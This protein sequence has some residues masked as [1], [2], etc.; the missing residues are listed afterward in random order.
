MVGT[1]LSGQ[2][3]KSTKQKQENLVEHMKHLGAAG[4]I[5]AP[6]PQMQ[7]GFTRRQI[8][9]PPS[10]IRKGSGKSRIKTCATSKIAAVLMR[11]RH[12]IPVVE[13]FTVELTSAG[14]V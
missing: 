1:Q 4:V 10:K 13:I 5:I 14:E 3:S 11:L 9:T 7:G 2:S 6:R 12:V 8:Q